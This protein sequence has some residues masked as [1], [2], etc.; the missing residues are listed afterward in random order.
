MKKDHIKRQKHMF[1]VVLYAVIIVGMYIAGANEKKTS[2]ADVVDIGAVDIG[3]TV[4]TNIV[5]SAP[6]ISS[7]TLNCSRVNWESMIPVNDTVVLDNG[8]YKVDI[9][10]SPI[11]STVIESSGYRTGGSYTIVS[12]LTANHDYYYRLRARDA[13]RL[14]EES[15]YSTTQTCRTSSE[16]NSTP[17]P[18][19]GGIGSSYASANPISSSTPD[20]TSPTSPISPVE[21]L[22]DTDSAL[23]WVKTIIVDPFIKKGAVELSVEAK[24]IS[25]N[26]KLIYVRPK[27]MPIERS[28]GN[29]CAASMDAASILSRTKEGTVGIKP[30]DMDTS[31]ILFSY[32]DEQKRTWEF[33]PTYVNKTKK[34]IDFKAMG[35]G[36]Y[37]M[38]KVN[39][40]GGTFKDIRPDDWFQNFAENV[41]M[42]KINNGD[43]NG[44][45]RGNSEIK[46]GE[47]YAM[48][49]KAFN[50][51]I[52]AKYI[53]RDYFTPISRGEA[54]EVLLTSID[55]MPSSANAVSPFTDVRRSSRF[56]AYIA[57]A[58]EFDI[59]KGFDD[60]TF[61]P[62][63]TVT[64]A[65]MA[66]III[67]A[68]EKRY[69]LK[70]LS[71]SEVKNFLCS[72][73]A[74][75][76]ISVKKILGGFFTI[77]HEYYE[78]KEG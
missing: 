55:F 17:D 46:R 27:N 11:F 63:A 48:I 15:N 49:A 32:F 51:I 64:R 40:V 29:R 2:F 71:D 10:S 26:A 22:P 41:R 39:S 5:D 37:R 12:S 62:N 47:A 65:E 68:I 78:A 74:N 69:L 7:I 25:G 57:Q 13:G 6:T 72:E 70:T 1:R 19:G 24:E 60:G 20:T 9:S 59:I 21:S 66:K 28:D 4:A 3:A 34:T 31:N 35:A 77:T 61:R 33:I 23:N 67:K 53:Q 14:T 43:S 76:T 16:N 75:S 30:A 52:P 58:F 38:E 42:M 50:I 8:E 73:V 18:G 44:S 45:F 54:L 56:Y 36:T